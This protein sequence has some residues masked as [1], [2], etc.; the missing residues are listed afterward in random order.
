[1]SGETTF[2][3]QGANTQCPRHG[4][5]YSRQPEVRDVIAPGEGEEQFAWLS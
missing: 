4:H 2:Y 1:M 3:T 5:V